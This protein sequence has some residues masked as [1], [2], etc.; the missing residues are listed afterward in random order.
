MAVQLSCVLCGFQQTTMVNLH[1]VEKS[2]VGK[3]NVIECFEQALASLLTN[4]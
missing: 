1:F 3:K 2:H 4:Q